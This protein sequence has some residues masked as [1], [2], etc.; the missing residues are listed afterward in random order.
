MSVWTVDPAD[1]RW[2]EFDWSSF[3]AAGETISSYTVTCDANLTK[4]ADA[5]TTTTVLIQVYGGTAGTQSLITCVINTT[6]ATGQHNRYETE[7]YVSI[8]TR[9]S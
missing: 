3:L 1:Q 6:N 7:K 2:F 4:L 5:A 9:F 8:R